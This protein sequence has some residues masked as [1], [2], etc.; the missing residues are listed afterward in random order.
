MTIKWI[1]IWI[2]ENVCVSGVHNGMHTGVHSGVHTGVH[3]GV[4]T[5]GHNGVHTGVHNG[6]H[7]GHACRLCPRVHLSRSRL[8]TRSA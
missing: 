5:R 2:H 1:Q 8:F 4:H 7:I 6:M 3:N